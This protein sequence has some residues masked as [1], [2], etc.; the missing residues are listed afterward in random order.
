MSRSYKKF[1]HYSDGENGGARFGKKFANKKVRRTKFDELPKKGKGYKKFYEQWDIRDFTSHW[2]WEEAITDYRS[3][4]DL[5]RKCKT[6][7]DFYRYW[8]KLMKAK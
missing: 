6:E 3:N 4:P 7:K 1:P 8:Y 5:Y 2:T